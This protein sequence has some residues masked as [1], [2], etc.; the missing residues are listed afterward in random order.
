MLWLSVEPPIRIDLVW[1]KHHWEFPINKK[2][3]PMLTCPTPE[4]LC[5]TKNKAIALHSLAPDHRY[6]AAVFAIPYPLNHCHSLKQILQA[7]LTQLASEPLVRD[8]QYA[9]EG[10]VP[11]QLFFERLKIR[12]LMCKESENKM[13]AKWK[14]KDWR[15]LQIYHIWRLKNKDQLKVWRLCPLRLHTDFGEQIVISK[16]LV[17][18][19]Y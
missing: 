10:W 18:K 15:F 6:G 13:L 3:I 17:C 2:I 19:H 4:K 12:F 1:Y 11:H 14:N 16:D 5:F 8:L 9:F 7:I